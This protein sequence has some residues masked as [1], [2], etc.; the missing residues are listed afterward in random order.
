MILSVPIL[1]HCRVG[2]SNIEKNA[3]L[4]KGRVPQRI[5]FNQE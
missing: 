3:V 5:K 4:S 1:K 2:Y